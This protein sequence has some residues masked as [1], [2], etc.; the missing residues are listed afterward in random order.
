M[1][2]SQPLADISKLTIVDEPEILIEDSDIGE[3]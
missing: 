1:S 2:V 3:L